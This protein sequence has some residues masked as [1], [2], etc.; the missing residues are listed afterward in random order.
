M[1][2]LKTFVGLPNSSLLRYTATAVNLSGAPTDL[3]HDKLKYQAR[4]WLFGLTTFPS[5]ACV[6]HPVVIDELAQ[7]AESTAADFYASQ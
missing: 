6:Q 2:A 3:Q 5:A 1:Q 7:S 4:T